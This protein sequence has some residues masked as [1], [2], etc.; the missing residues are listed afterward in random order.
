MFRSVKIAVVA[1]DKET[2]AMYCVALSAMG[3]EVVG[4]VGNGRD[5]V[6]LCANL[7]PNLIIADIKAPG[8]NVIEPAELIRKT[9][10]VPIMFV[11]D[12]YDEQL[13]QRVQLNHLV[14]YLLKP[15][16]ARELE[17]TISIT[18]A[19]FEEFK[20]ARA[21]AASLQQAL[22]DRKIVER[23]KGIL[24]EHSELS[25]HEAYRRLQKLSWDRNEKLVKVAEALVVAETA[26]AS[27]SQ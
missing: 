9:E 11:S 8:M 21:E 27:A 7:Q 10:P 26:L 12:H 17:T 23:A 22:R 25:E 5:L 1:D 16:R 20:R 18:V 4:D 6:A 24:M 19:R 15:L 3:H 13:I 14:A 2:R